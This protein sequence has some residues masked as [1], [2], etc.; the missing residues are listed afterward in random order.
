LT[1]YKV[2]R[3]LPFTKV[4]VATQ[5]INVPDSI[6]QLVVVSQ[7]TP[8]GLIGGPY[9]VALFIVNPLSAVTA[10][11]ATYAVGF[12]TAGDSPTTGV[13]VQEYTL[14]GSTSSFLN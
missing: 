5:V 3:P 2:E 6:K 11:V 13:V 9:T 12:T 7:I 14:N 8:D 1:S 4:E 10:F